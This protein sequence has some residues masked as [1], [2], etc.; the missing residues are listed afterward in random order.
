MRILVH[1]YAGHPFQAQLSRELARRGHVVSHAFRAKPGGRSGSLTRLPADPDTLTFRPIRLS[2]RAAQSIGVRNRL[3]H[4]IRYAQTIAAT[5]N[6]FGPDAVISSNTPLL[7]QWH[8]MNA[9]RRQRGAFVYWMQ[10]L[11]SASQ[12]RRLHRRPAVI[13]GPASAAVRWLERSTLTGAHAVV[14]VTPAFGQ[15]LTG[16]GVRPERVTVIANWS[17]LDEIVPAP[18]D[19]GW[20]REHELDHAMVFMYAGSLGLKHDP[21]LLVELA[22]CLP[23]VRLIVVAEGPGADLV[24]KESDRLGLT[25][26][27]VLPSQ[28]YAQLSNV[29]GTADVLVALLDGEGGDYSVPSKVLSYLCAER[30]ILASIPARNLAAQT[31]TQAGGGVVVEP[32]TLDDWLDAARRLADN[33]E[34]RARLGRNGRAYARRMFDIERIGNEFESVLHQAVAAGM[35]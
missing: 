34:L 5:L 24:R 10:D 2:P 22:R 1:D 32:G 12:I 15:A 11:I 4:E 25:N 18:R 30:A 31:L 35:R 29:L 17:P 19:N 20:A 28:P 26:V 13:A 9:T 27:I 8:V 16:Y 3:R 23:D 21:G 6:A 7:V 33:T 14:A